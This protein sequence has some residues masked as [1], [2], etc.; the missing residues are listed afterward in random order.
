MLA[1][2]APRGVSYPAPAMRPA[3]ALAVRHMSRL[4]RKPI[5]L[6]QSVKASMEPYPMEELLPVKA[7]H[8]R[9]NE[10][11]ILR[12]R[13]RKDTFQ[14]FG[15]PQM[16]RIDGPLGSLKVPIHSQCEVSILGDEQ[17]GCEIQVNPKCKG[18]TKLGRTMWGTTRAYIA[19]AVHGV[20]QGF[21]KELELHGVGFK[22]RVEDSKASAPPA[23]AGSLKEKTVAEA[24]IVDYTLGMK[25]YGKRVAAQ[26]GVLP[27]IPEDAPTKGDNL[28]LR[29]GFSHE[30]RLQFPPHLTVTTPTPTQIIIT[31]IDAQS[32]GQAAARVRQ[33]KKPEPYKGKGVRYAGEFVRLRPGKRR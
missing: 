19:S 13:P 23:A 17:R 8:M 1:L 4:G 27:V 24:P 29:V 10:K 7:L 18:E 12:N 33:V 15:P 21:R 11:Y 5:P 6:P 31:G 32:V 2:R 26:A 20:S 30:V 9:Q 22:A 28:I 14:L 25:K 16:I 3:M